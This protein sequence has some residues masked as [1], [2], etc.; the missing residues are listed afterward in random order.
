MLNATY[1]TYSSANET[2]QVVVTVNANGVSLNGGASYITAGTPVVVQ[3][4]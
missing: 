1:S 4:K 3:I 2:T